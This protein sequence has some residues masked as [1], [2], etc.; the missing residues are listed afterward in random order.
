MCG[1][2]S[3]LSHLDESFHSTVS[4]DDCSNINIMEKC[5]I[6]IKIK[7]GFVETIS[8]VYY[9]PNLKS[10][11]LSAGQLQ[12]KGYVI[13]IQKGACKIYDPTK[14]AIAIIQMSANR[15]FSLKKQATQSCLMAEVKN[16]SWL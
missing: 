8:N 10:N 1:S 14:R 7:N 12:E 16:S 15:L 9:V 4:F 5:D 2:K 11:L 6:N 3:L 13:T